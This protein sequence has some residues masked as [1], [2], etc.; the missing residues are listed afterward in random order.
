[1]SKP[2]KNYVLMVLAPALFVPITLALA[3]REQPDFF[4][5]LSSDFW[6]GTTIGATI[7]VALLGIRLLIRSRQF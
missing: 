7:V 2:N 1:M 6:A 3:R 4:L 5:G